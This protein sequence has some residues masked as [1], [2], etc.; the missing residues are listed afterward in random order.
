[1][2]WF[3]S[4][5]IS[6]WDYKQATFQIFRNY[7]VRVA[8]KLN[9]TKN[10]KKKVAHVQNPE[11]FTL[12][13]IGIRKEPKTKDLERKPLSFAV[14]YMNYKKI[15]IDLLSIMINTLFI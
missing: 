5:R 9:I 13:I 8:M 7:R 3:E 6:I 12:C 14:N 2:M 10:I 4:Q 11:V 1:M 15:S